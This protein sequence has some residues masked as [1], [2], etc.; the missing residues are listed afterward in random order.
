MNTRSHNEAVPTPPEAVLGLLRSLG[1]SSLGHDVPPS[2]MRVAELSL[3]ELKDQLKTNDEALVRKAFELALLSM[4]EETRRTEHIDRKGASLL[5]VVMVVLGIGPALLARAG[6]VTH[7]K[8]LLLLGTFLLLVGSIFLMASIWSRRWSGLSDRAIF[9]KEEWGTDDNKPSTH[10]YL[11]Y[12]C[13]HLWDIYCWNATV[14]NKKGKCLNFAQGFS[15]AG[16]VILVLAV[17]SS[18]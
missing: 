7:S 13:T 17:I 16:L 1:L 11:R 9:Y 5:S 8:I 2:K 3:K 15:A 4:N 18:I 12:L 10:D 14:N 6:L